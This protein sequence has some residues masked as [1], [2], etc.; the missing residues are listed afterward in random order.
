MVAVALMANAAVPVVAAED[1]ASY[2]FVGAAAFVATALAAVDL[3]GV[4]IKW[5]LSSPRSRKMRVGL[6]QIPA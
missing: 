4:A 2:C 3:A 6:H 1:E 5:T